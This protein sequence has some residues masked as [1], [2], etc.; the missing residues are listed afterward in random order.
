M[1]VKS[2]SMIDD[3]S[4]EL[5]ENIL[6]ALGVNFSNRIEQLILEDLERLITIIELV[7]K[8]GVKE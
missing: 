3:K 6:K 7:K 1:K 8:E 4:L 5:Y 2:F